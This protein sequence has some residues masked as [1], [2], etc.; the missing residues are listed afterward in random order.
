MFSYLSDIF[1]VLSDRPLPR[2]DLAHI[3]AFVLVT[4]A[5][6]S[7]SNEYGRTLE[8]GE[9]ISKSKH[10]NVANSMLILS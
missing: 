7:R 6:T 3:A 10:R 8:S 2:R 1:S 5:N 9:I 4:V